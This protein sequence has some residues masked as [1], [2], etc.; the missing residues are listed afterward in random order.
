[1]ALSPTQYL[2]AI[3]PQLAA[4][5]NLSVY[6]EMATNQVS[7]CFFGTNY[8]MAVALRAAHIYTLAQRP[9]GDSGQISSKREGDLSV[10]YS[11]TSGESGGD[12]LNQ[13]H[14]GKQYMQLAKQSGAAMSVLGADLS[15]T[16]N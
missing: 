9:L 6:L 12:D 11:T 3:C 14:Y 13:T 2:A 15:N 8:N 5:A 16:C 1:M 4:D 10:S 7:G